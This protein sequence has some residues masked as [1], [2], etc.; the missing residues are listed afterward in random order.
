M[1][2]LLRLSPSPPNQTK[3][4]KAS[5]WQCRMYRPLV[6][7]QQLKIGLGALCSSPPLSP[8][9]TTADVMLRSNSVRGIRDPFREI[10]LC[11]PISSTG[12]KKKKLRTNTSGVRQRQGADLVFSFQ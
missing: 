4:H 2:V 5:A 8:L 10:R 3:P 7:V 12:K 11:L 1:S 9:S 6:C